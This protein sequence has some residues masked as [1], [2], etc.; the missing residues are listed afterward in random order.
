MI[1]IAE[2][3]EKIVTGPVILPSHKTFHT[4]MSHKH[5]CCKFSFGNYYHSFGKGALVGEGASEQGLELERENI[6]PSKKRLTWCIAVKMHTNKNVYPFVII[7]TDRILSVNIF[8]LHM[9]HMSFSTII[10]FQK[11]HYRLFCP[12][13]SL[14]TYCQRNTERTFDSGCPTDAKRREADRTR[15]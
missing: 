10:T 7:H 15:I 9:A 13:W 5:T 2:N 12:F 8:H 6:I 11:G 4:V 14:A 1:E 3:F